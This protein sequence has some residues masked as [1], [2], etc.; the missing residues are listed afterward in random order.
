MRLTPYE[1]SLRL[2][3]SAKRKNLPPG[4]HTLGDSE[5]EVE[6]PDGMVRVTAIF[7]DG[8]GVSMFIRADELDRCVADAHKTVAA[9]LKLDPTR[10][11]DVVRGRMLI[12]QA[13]KNRQ[14]D[15]AGF[16]ALYLSWNYHGAPVPD[17]VRETLAEFGKACITLA[18]D[19]RLEHAVT[20]VGRDYGDPFP[21]ISAVVTATTPAAGEA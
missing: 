20:I 10:A 18:V 4:I 17:Q 14:D 1:A 7:Q 2:R 5:P 21:L 8:N 6:T 13:V 12:H 9:C 15:A 11:E 3:R 19:W 16:L